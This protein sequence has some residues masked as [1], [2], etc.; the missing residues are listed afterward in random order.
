MLIDSEST[1]NIL[2]WNAYQKIGLKRADLHSTTSPLYEF[3]GESVIPEGIIKLVVTLEEAPR[4]TTIVDDFLVVNYLSTFNGVLG[5][6][7]LRTMKAVT[8]IYCLTMKFPT[9]ARMDQV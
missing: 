2:Y 4:I 6:P 1:V 5:K 7:L 9:T 8:F 3:T